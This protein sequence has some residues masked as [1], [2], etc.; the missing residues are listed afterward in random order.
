MKTVQTS[1]PIAENKFRK[2]I[3]ANIFFISIFL[4]Y[5]S[6]TG[7]IIDGDKLAIKLIEGYQNYFS[8]KVPFIKCKYRISCSEYSKNAI[9][10]HGLKKGIILSFKRI[11]SCM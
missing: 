6:L 2:I 1:V 3:L 11:N 10:E 4:G 9:K 8:D 7:N 5:S